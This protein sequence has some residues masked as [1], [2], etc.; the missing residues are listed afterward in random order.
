MALRQHA[1][2][3]TLVLA[4]ALALGTAACSRPAPDASPEGAVR[5]WLDRME[6]SA[7]DRKAAREAF[8]LLGPSARANLEERALRA[9]RVHGRQVEPY[10]MLAEG[11][12]GLRFRPQTMTSTVKG[13]EAVVEVLGSSAE[14]EHATVRCRFDPEGKGW[15]VEPGLPEPPPLQHREDG[16]L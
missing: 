9:S 6:Q 2:A 5:L 11:R 4:L 3:P 7:D 10:E 15:R 14:S 8:A 1:R 16:G 13:D 12:F